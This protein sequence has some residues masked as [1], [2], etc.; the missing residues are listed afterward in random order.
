MGLVMRVK[1]KASA[2]LVKREGNGQRVKVMVKGKVGVIAK[3]MVRVK[4]RVS[5]SGVS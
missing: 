3:V 1:M 2:R 5:V 4:T